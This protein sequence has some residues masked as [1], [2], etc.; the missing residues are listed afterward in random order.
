MLLF[1]FGLYVFF[2]FGDEVYGGVLVRPGVIGGF[3]ERFPGTSKLYLFLLDP[4]P[5]RL[6]FYFHNQ[7]YQ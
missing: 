4:V 6:L 5:G 3:P 7:S 2:V 1:S